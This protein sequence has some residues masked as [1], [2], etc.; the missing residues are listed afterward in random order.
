MPEISKK[1]FGELG[2]T[3]V[4]ALSPGSTTVNY[5]GLARF[6]WLWCSRADSRD[7]PQVGTA[8]ITYPSAFDVLFVTSKRCKRDLQYRPKGQACNYAMQATRHAAL[9][10]R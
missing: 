4:L 8:H 10:F 9:R 3:L 5:Y 7:I 1:R 6:R 2:I